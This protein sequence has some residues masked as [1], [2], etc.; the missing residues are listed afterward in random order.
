MGGMKKQ[1]MQELGNIFEILIIMVV[2]YF[3]K[4]YKDILMFLFYII[5]Y[6]LYMFYIYLLIFY[7]WIIVV[8]K[9]NVL[10]IDR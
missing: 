9:C 4:V 6:K 7:V 3:Q 5:V 1:I 2:W 10:F 8:I